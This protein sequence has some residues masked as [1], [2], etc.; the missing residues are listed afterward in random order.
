MS[1]FFQFGA[2]LLAALNMERSNCFF[3]T[4]RVEYVLKMPKNVRILLVVIENHAFEVEETLFFEVPDLC[5]D[6]RPT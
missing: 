4:F 1:Y 6:T 5:R 2:R 3:W